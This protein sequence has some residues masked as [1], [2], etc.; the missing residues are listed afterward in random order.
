MRRIWVLVVV[1]CGSRP[2]VPVPPAAPTVAEVTEPR[3][4]TPAACVITGELS[5]FACPPDPPA[6]P[7]ACVVERVDLATGKTVD[8]YELAGNVLLRHDSVTSDIETE[9]RF[10]EYDSRGRRVRE[11]ECMRSQ[12]GP[13]SWFP[14]WREPQVLH[15]LPTTRATRTEL[16]Y[17]GDALAS[18]VIISTET[19]DRPYLGE[20][21][22]CYVDNDHGRRLQR[23][24]TSRFDHA[25]RIGTNVRSYG[26]AGELL[27]GITFGQLDERGP[28]I[29]VRHVARWTVAFEYDSA[30]RMIGRRTELPKSPPQIERFRYD[31]QGRP[32]D[33]GNVLLAW[34]GD[35]LR[36]ITYPGI[37]QTFTYLGSGRLAEAHYAQG[38]YRM[39]YG[40]RCAPGL[41][42]HE[43][44]PDPSPWLYFEGKYAL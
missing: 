23:W 43:L 17:A 36:S 42:H 26:Y 38:G 41:T 19:A 29:G 20:Q 13:A 44:L 12:G 39:V 2:V 7:D 32:I 1:G 9:S 34:D 30:K 5:V 22:I 33:A 6:N 28:P 25:T 15:E 37:D 14:T 8:R 27:R 21:R 4:I 35:R 24:E 11:T 18:A 16:T 10:T 31:A 40:A 3:W